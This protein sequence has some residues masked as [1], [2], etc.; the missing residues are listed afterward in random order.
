M[1]VL[2]FGIDDVQLGWVYLTLKAVVSQQ[3]RP[4][5]GRDAL[6][7]AR[8]AGTT[9]RPA[10]LKPAIDPIGFALV[11]GDG[12]ELCNR[13]VLQALPSRAAVVRECHA[14]VV[15]EDQ[16][17]RIAR[18]DPEGMMIGVRALCS[19]PVREGLAAVS[20]EVQRYA[21]NIDALIVVGVDTN[22]AEIERP[23]ANIVAFR[24]GLPAIV[25]AEDSAGLD[26]AA[27]PCRLAEFGVA[28]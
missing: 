7:A 17:T 21:Q 16:M 14:A 3:A 2:R 20:R 19:V 4:V 13:Q 8:G 28:V 25:G 10:V 23:R 5:G 27:R 22:L 9:P 11:H 12:V 24:P 6:A 18:V 1:A 26:V 15:A